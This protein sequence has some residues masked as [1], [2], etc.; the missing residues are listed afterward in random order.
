M[1]FAFGRNWQRFVRLLG[2]ERIAATESYLRLI[3]GVDRLDGHRFLDVGSGSGLSSLAA[4]RLGARVH[5]FDYDEAS[6]ACTAGLRS[7][8]CPTGDNWRVERGSAL[9]AEYL[10]SLG[11]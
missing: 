7:R 1:T 3:L 5:S 6:V 9:D 8:Y 11:T 2:E 10:K 4:W